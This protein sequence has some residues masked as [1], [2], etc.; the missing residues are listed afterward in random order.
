VRVEFAGSPPVAAEVT[1]A[2]AAELRLMPGQVAWVAV[3]ATET[4]AYPA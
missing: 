3:K 4:H 2:A 1:T